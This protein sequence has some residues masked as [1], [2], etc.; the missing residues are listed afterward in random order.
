MRPFGRVLGLLPLLFLLHPL[1]S[2]ASEPP[3]SASLLESGRELS[4][5]AQVFLVTVGPG[6][7]VWE[8]F[9]HNGLLVRDPETGFSRIYDWGRFSFQSKDFWP[10]FLRGEMYYAIGSGNPDLFLETNAASDRDMWAQEINLS[11][12]QK[13]ALLRFLKEN[14]RE[15]ERFYRYDYF[16]DNCSTRARD[17]LDRVLGGIIARNTQSKGS[18]TSFR[19][20][21]RRLLQGLPAAYF[22][23]QLG[24]GRP[25]D[26]EI[27]LWE[28]SFTPMALRRQLNEIALPDGA[29]LILSDNQ[30]YHSKSLSEAMEVSERID[31]FAIYG[32]IGGLLLVFLGY[33]SRAGKK[34]AEKALVFFGAG[35]SLFS[36]LAG[37]LL[38]LIWAFTEHRFGHWN[39]NLLQH[40]PLSLGLALFFLGFFFRGS[41]SSTAARLASGAAVLSLVGLLLKLF[42]GLHQVNGEIIA[43]ALPVHLALAWAVNGLQARKKM[44]SLP[45]PRRG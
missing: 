15:G 45:L 43:F 26:K 14:D 35:W 9:G 1:A 33:L 41:W 42:P 19:A 2:A 11:L 29:P 21:T 20:H 36:G 16:L 24:L 44:C 23:I 25:S 34:W 37:L 39:E 3:S 30:I 40:N 18:K 10:R 8:R 38:A 31:F 32:G 5:K 13:N 7:L 28:A 4:E 6:D 12:A 27:S 22:G 17:A